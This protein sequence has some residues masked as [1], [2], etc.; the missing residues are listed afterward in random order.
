MN[1]LVLEDPTCVAG[2]EQKVSGVFIP[3]KTKADGSFDARS[4]L[5]TLEQMGQIQRHIELVLSEMA[6]IF[7]TERLRLFR[8][9]LLGWSPVST[10]IISRSASMVR[11]VRAEN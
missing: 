7:R 11:T 4:S 9:P 3:V 8:C 1:G 10:V 6:K 5:A 2:M